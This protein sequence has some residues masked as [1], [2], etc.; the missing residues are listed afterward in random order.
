MKAAWLLPLLLLENDAK[1]GALLPPR[2]AS[3]L[4]C[5][6]HPNQHASCPATATYQHVCCPPPRPAGITL[7]LQYNCQVEQSL[8]GNATVGG[9]L[10][11]I[12]H[13]TG[14]QREG[15]AGGVLPPTCVGH[16]SVER[17]AGKLATLADRSA[18]LSRCC[19]A[20]QT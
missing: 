9:L 14:F 2:L 5:P 17:V 10:P 8:E 13:F 19:C 3:L 12:V 11:K 18:A 20:W 6:R 1:A 4:P 7:P 15:V 16:L